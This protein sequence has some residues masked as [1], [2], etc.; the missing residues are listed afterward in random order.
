MCG[1]CL[2][3]HLIYLQWE[4][5]KKVGRWLYS[6]EVA[7]IQITQHMHSVHEINNIEKDN[8]HIL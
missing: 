8:P 3:Y 5:A 6:T 2:G 1:R 4:K 7:E